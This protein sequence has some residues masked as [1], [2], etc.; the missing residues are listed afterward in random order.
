VEGGSIESSAWI[1]LVNNPYRDQ[2][3]A[4]D[5]QFE[6]PAEAILEGIAVSINRS[7]EMVSLVADYEVK[8]LR[9]GST[10]GLDRAKTAAWS[11]VFQYVNYGGPSDLWGASWTAADL[12]STGFGVA[13]TPMYLSTGGN[14]RAY[15]DFI[16]ATAYY[17]LPCS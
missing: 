7:A 11:T 9:A 10:V 12:N 13:L 2:L 15:V 17:S 14:G 5:F 4:S 8:L 1:I 3:L 6:L 16:R